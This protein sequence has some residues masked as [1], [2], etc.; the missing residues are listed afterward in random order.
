MAFAAETRCG[1]AASQA[2]M[3]ATGRSGQA[4]L[5]AWPA[6]HEIAVAHFQNL[7]TGALQD[8]Q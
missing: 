6:R 5:R 1:R 8:S 7:V 2:Q 3:P 4:L